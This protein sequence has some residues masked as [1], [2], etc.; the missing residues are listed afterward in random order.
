MQI[1]FDFKSA[2][3]HPKK[4]GWYTVI[5]KHGDVFS[6]KWD[7]DWGLP[8]VYWAE[9]PDDLISLQDMLFEKWAE[10]EL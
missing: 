1:T 4:T 6:D 3:E 2:D 10:G 5:T 8:V 9:A 7:G